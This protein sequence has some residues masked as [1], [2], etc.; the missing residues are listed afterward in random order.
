MR[1]K[2][3]LL[4]TLLLMSGA[5]QA[6]FSIPSIP[7]IPIDLPDLGGLLEQEPV[8]TTGLDDAVFECPEMDGFE[9]E[10][11]TPL[12]DMPVNPDGWIFLLPGAYELE[13]RSYCLHAG[14]YVSDTGGNGYI[15]APLEGS[16]S[17]IILAILDRSSNHGEINQTEVQ[18]LIWAVL[19][20]CK[21]SDMSDNKQINASILLTPEEIFELNGGALGLI[22]DG[23]LDDLFGDITGPVRSVLEAEAGIRNTLSRAESSYEELEEIAIIHGDPPEEYD[24]RDIPVGR[25]SWHPNGYYIRYFPIGYKHTRIE[26]W[27]PENENTELSYGNTLLKAGHTGLRKDLPWLKDCP[28]PPPPPSPYRSRS[29]P[30]FKPPVGVAQPGN[31]LRQR[32]AVAAGKSPEQVDEAIKKIRDSMDMFSSAAGILA[33]DITSIFDVG[34]EIVGWMSGNMLDMLIDKWSDS[35]KALGMDPPRS[36]YTIYAIPLVVH[37]DSLIPGNGLSPQKA[38]ALNSFAEAA[39]G[40]IAVMDAAQISLDRMGGA[41]DDNDE[42]WA[43]EQALCYIYYKDLSGVFMEIAAD[44]FDHLFDVCRLEGL[45]DTYITVAMASAYLD[46]LEENGF[47]AEAIEAAHYLGMTDEQIQNALEIRLSFTPQDLEGSLFEAADNCISFMHECG[48]QWQRMPDVYP[49][50]TEG[51]EYPQYAD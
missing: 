23:M 8:I 28:V 41:F 21:I 39:M 49:Y 30:W 4:F 32:L 44:R 36:D 2:L 34:S 33:I 7:D 51:V 35:I 47:S 9:P 38:A 18:S 31:T 22:P 15:Y 1:N 24:E 27:V 25:W 40:L 50:W 26:L 43:I 29:L 12:Y 10:F 5:A 11:L 20:R 46:N 14:T 6:Q 19:A 45:Q 3:S 13:A 17:D 42:F 16:R 48:S 37:V